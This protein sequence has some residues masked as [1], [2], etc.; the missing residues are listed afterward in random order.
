MAWMWRRRARIIEVNSWEG[1]QQM[2]PRATPAVIS[3]LAL[4]ALISPAAGTDPDRDFSG[5][6]LLDEQQS[7][8]RALT[9][10]PPAVLTTNHQGPPI[11]C[12]K[13]DKEEKPA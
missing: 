8:A 12:T 4:F 1:T 3:F 10:L 5:V 11:Q 6:W 2:F 7:D 9:P 13:A